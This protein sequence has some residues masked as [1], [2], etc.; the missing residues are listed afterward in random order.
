LIFAGNFQQ[1]EV[2]KMVVNKKTTLKVK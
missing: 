1:N 2:Q